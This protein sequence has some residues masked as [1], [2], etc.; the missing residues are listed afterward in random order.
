MTRLRRIASAFWL[1]LALLAGQ[2]VAALHGLAHATEQFTQK[3]DSPHAP[4]S[5]D[6]CFACA[7]LSSAAAA[8]VPSLPVVIAG[9]YLHL[10]RFEPGTSPAARLA[11]RSRAPPTLL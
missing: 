7:E 9:S 11:F 6:K 8:T 2:H 1:A 10:A 3:K 5:C 4:A